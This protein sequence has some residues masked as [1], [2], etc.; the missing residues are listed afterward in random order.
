MSYSVKLVTKKF[1]WFAIAICDDDI[2]I[3]GGFLFGSTPSHP[4]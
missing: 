1:G 2:M 4:F 3:H